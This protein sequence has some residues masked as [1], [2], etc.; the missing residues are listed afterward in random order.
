MTAMTGMT[1]M[2][3]IAL[4]TP[5]TAE[6]S[7]ELP[8]ATI[9]YLVLYVATLLMHAVFMSYVLSGTIVL[10]AAGLRDLAGGRAR[11]A[12]E[13]ADSAWGATR[14]MLKDWMPFALSAAITAGIAPLLFV[15]LLYQ[16]EFYTANLLLF[17]RWMAILPVLIVAFYL[18]YLL[19]AK[20]LEGRTVL[21]GSV[22]V[23]AAG[24]VVF[25][26]WSWVENHLLSL[27]RDAWAPLY[28]SRAMFYATPAILPRLAMWIAMAFPTAAALWAWQLRAGASGVGVEQA[29]RATRALAAP[30]LATLACGVGLAWPVLRG[31]MPEGVE[32]GR[33]MTAGAACLGAG[34]LLQA[35]VWVRGASGRGPGLGG[36]V[37]ASAGVALLWGGTL[38]MREAAR[39]AVL[40][41]PA[42]Y[43]RHE[44][45]GTVAG[46]VVFLVCACAGLATVAWVV[47][48]VARGLK[49][50]A[51]S[52]KA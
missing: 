42:L 44:R 34:A 29:A 41:G 25:V 38:V 40:G 10:G 8:S 5:I 9:W 20:R 39:L 11:K 36:L 17:H 15:Q 49:A 23:A 2:T 22:A 45:V 16:Q 52:G 30:S 47:R 21:R 43:A 13:P 7:G 6:P 48:T 27:R 37:S 24:C 3:A 51:V 32:P 18:L 12:R 19:K 4:M 26:A 50:A 14:K 31:G 46:L 33:A 35:I 28:A 1:G